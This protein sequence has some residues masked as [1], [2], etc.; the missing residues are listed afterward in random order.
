MSTQT[1]AD[2]GISS[3]LLGTMILVFFIGRT[4]ARKGDDL[5]RVT[6]LGGSLVGLIFLACATS[7]PELITGVATAGVVQ[8]PNLALGNIFGSCLFNLAILAVMD[9]LSRGGPVLRTVGKAQH[10]PACVGFVM[11]GI[12]AA[13]VLFVS[14]KMLPA[15]WGAG[16]AVALLFAY[17]MG[18]HFI[19]KGTPRGE[20][21]G[22]EEAGDREARLAKRAR[23]LKS[24][25]WWSLWMI[26]AALALSWVGDQVSRYKFG[27]TFQF[28]ATWVGT[29]FLA[30]ATSLPEL[31]VSITAVRLGATEM[32]VGNILGS[33]LFNLAVV[34]VCQLSAVIGK[35]PP[36]LYEANP[37]HLL[38]A[39]AAM[40]LTA[41]VYVA[42]RT[43]PK[44]QVGGV[45]IESI[46]IAIVYIGAMVA[47][48]LLGGS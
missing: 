33:N 45:G 20:G 39:G 18:L 5:G 26:V 23:T 44:F 15:E 4:L 41:V 3:A 28:G 16:F 47:I 1:W 22:E 21:P 48:F 7:M 35:A 36:V 6:G 43:R 24:F 12:G 42:I 38:T 46:V 8:A 34:P 25:L 29:F 37:I 30:F 9:V 10:M 11:I 40:L 31:S 14:P 27:G 19:H 17:L 13:G 2:L 32:A